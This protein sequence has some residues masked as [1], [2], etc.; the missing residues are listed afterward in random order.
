MVRNRVKRR[1][2][3]ALREQ[4]TRLPTGS[5]TVVRALPP[6][7][8]SSFAELSRDLDSALASLDDLVGVGSRP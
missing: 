6:A 2:R 8:P 3:A 5:L 4:M 1:L 7:A